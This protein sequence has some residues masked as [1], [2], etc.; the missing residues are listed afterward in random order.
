MEEKIETSDP[1]HTGK[2]LSQARDKLK[3]SQQ[4]YLNHFLHGEG[5]FP[6]VHLADLCRELR[7]DPMEFHE[8]CECIKNFNANYK[9]GSLMQINTSQPS[10]FGGPGKSR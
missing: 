8:F 1:V 3:I 7:L 10:L 4:Q 2:L 5:M 9:P 6:R